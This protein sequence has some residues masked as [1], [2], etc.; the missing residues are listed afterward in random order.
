MPP[1]TPPGDVPVSWLVVVK[2]QLRSYWLK[3]N[4]V[5]AAQMQ[6]PVSGYWSLFLLKKFRDM[7]KSINTMMHTLR[8]SCCSSAIC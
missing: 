5:K 7:T 3:K 4:A 1:V 8:Y 6:M 2:G